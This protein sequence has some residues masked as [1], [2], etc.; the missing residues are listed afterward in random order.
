MDGVP[1]DTPSDTLKPLPPSRSE[2]EACC[3]GT[4]EGFCHY[5]WIY[6]YNCSTGEVVTDVM[7]YPSGDSRK[8]GHPGVPI[9]KWTCEKTATESNPISRMYIWTRSS[10]P[11]VDG[12][13]CDTPSDTLKPLPPSRSEKEACCSGTGEGFCHYKWIY[14]YNCSTGEVVTD[15]MEYPSGDSR[16]CGHPGVPINKW[17]C[18]KTAT[19]SNPISRMYIW[20]R[21]SSPCVDGVP[22][23]TPSDTL[24]PLPPSRSEKEACCSGTGEGS[25]SGS[26]GGSRCDNPI[27]GIEDTA[28]TITYIFCNGDRQTISKCCDTS[29]T[30]SGGGGSGGDGSGGGGLPA[31]CWYKWYAT[32]D[33]ETHTSTL[34]EWSGESSCHSPNRRYTK[35]MEL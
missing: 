31:K 7:E 16:K 35:R 26:G 10:S 24:K 13:P 15:V 22:C 23:D 3:S 19:E 2:K 33:C 17:T 28:T 14:E 32:I 1:C 8:C 9:N 30:G 27:I 11:C 20:T 34:V 25:G 4:G 12:V 29:G 6:E 21:S 5:K 18:E